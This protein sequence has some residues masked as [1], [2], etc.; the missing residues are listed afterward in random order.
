MLNSFPGIFVVFTAIFIAVLVVAQVFAQEFLRTL[1][2]DTGR[3]SEGRRHRRAFEWTMRAGIGC[4][5]YFV[6]A[7]QMRG[8]AQ[9]YAPDVTGSLIAVQVG[10][11]ALGLI[12]LAASIYQLKAAVDRAW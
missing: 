7:Q 4:A 12:F 8:F 1:F 6:A 5:N 11:V 3:R 9:Q 10:L 2:H